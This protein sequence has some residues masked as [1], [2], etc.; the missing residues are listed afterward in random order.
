MLTAFFGFLA[1][2]AQWRIR[3]LKRTLDKKQ[4]DLERTSRLLIEKNLELSDQN[5]RL[6]KLLEAKTDFVGIASHQLRTPIT[7]IKWGLEIVQDGSLGEFTPMQLDHFTQLLDSANKMIRLIDDLLRLV[8]IE[9][10][11][12]EYHI[13]D[14]NI[15]ALIKRVAFRTRTLFAH[16]N[17]DLKYNFRFGN[18]SIP[19][20]EEMIEISLTNLME[21]AF[22]YTPQNGS[23]AIG[24][25]EVDKNFVCEIS[26]S[27]IGIPPEKRD[28]IFKKFQRSEVALHMN[29]GGIGLGLYIAKNI[30]EQ[31]HGQ[32]GFHSQPG[33]GTTF[34]I[35][36]PTQGYL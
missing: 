27:G 10:G 3:V 14:S 17:I 15:E 20:D 24:T 12:K 31:H 36:L 30:I 5:V 9:A 35:V 1:S 25:K 33:E 26:D 32:I 29:A 8:R 13:S 22:H 11:Y 19:I 16:K 28:A 2:R 21:N 34:F 18:T 7:E 23:V 4:Q 6:E